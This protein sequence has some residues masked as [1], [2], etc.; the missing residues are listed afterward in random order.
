MSKGIWKTFAL[1]IIAAGMPAW[2]SGQYIEGKLT[3]EQQKILDA[4][5]GLKVELQMDRTEYLPGEVATVRIRV[6]NRSEQAVQ[7][8][9]PFDYR[10]GGLDML[11]YVEFNGV[12]GYGPW[13]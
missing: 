13:F 12:A 1:G 10:T 11:H 4:T 5:R 9:K 8:F 2:L 7:V 3:P 6:T